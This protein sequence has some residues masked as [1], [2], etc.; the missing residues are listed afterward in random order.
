MKPYA[1]W[2]KIEVYNGEDFAYVLNRFAAKGDI[3][4]NKII[5]IERFK[6]SWEVL[7]IKTVE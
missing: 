7:H 1:V 4:L 5:Y 3:D 6:N 2:T